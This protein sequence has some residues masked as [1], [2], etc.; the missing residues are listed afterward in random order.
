MRDLISKR[1]EIAFEKIAKYCNKINHLNKRD[2]I[3]IMA[4]A[5]E[6]VN[7]DG[8]EIPGHELEHSF[9]V[10]EISIYLGCKMNASLD[11]LAIASLLHDVGRWIEDEEE[12]DH[13]ELSAKIAND[14]LRDHPMRDLIVRIIREHS[15]SS[16]KSPSSI[17]SA[18][19]QDADKIDALGFIGVARVFAFGG[20]N[21]RV[22]Y[23]AV[24]NQDVK[25]SLS[26]F[27]EKIL[28]LVEL[29]NTEL[30]RN[31]A[32]KRLE[33]VKFFVNEL[34]REIELQDFL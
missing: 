13:A 33:K 30:G 7:Y 25:S 16:N 5:L 28:K 26:H 6:A 23:S 31:I 4:K 24:Y 19:L 20:Y 27:Y 1:L 15:Y 9:R 34:R 12:T 2:L 29:M 8:R 21:G 17:E 18:I 32:K 22:I 10:F 11:L 14:V 3:Q